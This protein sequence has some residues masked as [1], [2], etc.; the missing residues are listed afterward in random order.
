M[1]MLTIIYMDSSK[2]IVGILIFI[3]VYLIVDTCIL[4]IRND[5]E[6]NIK[7]R[8]LSDV[9]ANS[10]A[11]HPSRCTPIPPRNKDRGTLRDLEPGCVYTKSNQDLWKEIE[12]LDSSQV[13]CDRPARKRCPLR[14]ADPDVG[15]DS[16]LDPYDPEMYAAYQDTC[17]QPRKEILKLDKPLTGHSFVSNDVC[18]NPAPVRYPVL[19][20][21]H[22]LPEQVEK[23]TFVPP[24]EHCSLV[25]S[26]NKIVSSNLISDK[27]LTERMGSFKSI[28]SNSIS[29]ELLPADAV[30]YDA[31][32]LRGQY[33][34]ADNNLYKVC[35]RKPVKSMD[36]VVMPDDVC[37]FDYRYSSYAEI[38]NNDLRETT[39]V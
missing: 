23:H 37:G 3:G 11:N 28:I 29:S 4:M 25:P 14:T 38:E 10:N 12:E 39:T 34:G 1:K 19:S 7:E 18:D 9:I 21:T 20:D 6:Q 8:V 35:D 31:R 22:Y 32:E 36:T 2:I 26:T 16:T 24:A 13:V 5:V 33:P 30:Q 15:A 17:G 27:M